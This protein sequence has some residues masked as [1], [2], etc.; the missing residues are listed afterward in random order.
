MN[1]DSYFH[2]DDGNRD[3]YFHSDDGRAQQTK[4]TN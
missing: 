1:R 4:E 2:S 3:N